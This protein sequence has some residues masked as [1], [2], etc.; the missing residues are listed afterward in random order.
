MR[1]KLIFFLSIFTASISFA[2]KE[3]CSFSATGSGV[4]TAFLSDYQCLGINPANLGFKRNP[5]PIHFSFMEVGASVYSDALQKKDIRHDF[6]YGGNTHFTSQQKIDAAE[7]FADNKFIA[8]ADIAWLSFAFQNSNFGGLAFSVREHATFS[9]VFNNDFAQIVFEGYHSPYFDSLVVHGTDTTGFSKLPKSIGQLADGSRVSACWYR[10]YVAGYGRKVFEGKDLSLYVGI[11][12]K[13]LAGYGILDLEAANGKLTGF[14]ALTPSL[15]VNYAHSTPSQITG[16]AMN[17]VGSGYGFDLGTTL[18][19]GKNLNLSTAVDDIGSIKWNGNVYEAKD[20]IVNNVSSQGFYS[21]QMIKEMKGL[22]QDSGL[23]NWKGTASHNIALPSNLRLGASYKIGK[24]SNIGI[25]CYVP[26]NKKS[27]NFD[28]AIISAGMN[29]AI[30]KLLIL[31]FGFETG[32]DY[33]FII[34]AGITFEMSGGKLEMGIASRD[35]IT[36]FKKN[37]PTISV[38][39]GFLRFNLGKVV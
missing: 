1:F 23:F 36:F 14:S 24:R 21:Y 29:L 11:D 18:T 39:F 15:G 26:L 30:A 17:S 10:E 38:A 6:I 37:N 16:S 12:V 27:G 25:D 20:S 7:A 22:V 32:G 5:A 2:Q 33:G 35:A 13:Y 34:P 19:L 9:S 4:A 3:L 28:K 31:S 8:N